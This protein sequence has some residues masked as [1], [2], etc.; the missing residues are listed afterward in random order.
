GLGLAIVNAVVQ[1]HRGTVGVTSEPG[2]TVFRV[3]L[4]I[5]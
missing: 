5:S 2:H 4:P 1:A 3:E